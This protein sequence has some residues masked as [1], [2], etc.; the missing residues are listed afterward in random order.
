VSWPRVW[1]IFSGRI[2]AESVF[3]IVELNSIKYKHNYFTKP[4]ARYLNYRKRHY[5]IANAEIVEVR[6][7]R[8]LD[9]TLKR[10]IETIEA[11]EDDDDSD[12]EEMYEYRPEVLRKIHRI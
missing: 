8:S 4:A 3:E 5:A 11:L 12:V 9:S 2:F 7:L 10:V 6:K 1:C